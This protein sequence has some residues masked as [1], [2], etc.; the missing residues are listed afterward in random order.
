MKHSTPLI[1]SNHLLVGTATFA[2]S[3]LCA[4]QTQ[5]TSVL[6]NGGFDSG[7]FTGWTLHADGADS[8]SVDTPGTGGI[9]SPGSDYATD[10][11]STANS[12]DSIYQVVSVPNAIAGTVT[13]TMSLNRASDTGQVGSGGQ[14]NIAVYGLNAGY[15]LSSA[16]SGAVPVGT[17]TSGG[18]LLSSA[19]Y[20]NTAI[21]TWVS[22]PT[23]GSLTSS[24]S[25]A[26]ASYEVLIYSVAQGAVTR[27][28]H[29]DSVSLDVPVP[30]PASFGLFGISGLCLLGRR[31]RA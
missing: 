27:N 23:G 18:T 13:A 9:L 22:L 4:R 30:E 8:W 10:H 25:V 31:R 19:Q 1:R 28:G 15:T 2:L 7:S 5:A 14:W 17:P 11:V 3:L 20:L 21:N 26:Y 12:I 24:P 29:F 6:T 16:V